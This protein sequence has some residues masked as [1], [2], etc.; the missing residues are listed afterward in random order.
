MTLQVGDQA[1]LFT[2]PDDNNQKIS[3]QDLRGKQ[4]VLYFYPKDETPGCTR[5]ACDFRDAIGK[6][7]Q[8]KVV[9]F[10]ISKDSVASH[11]KFKKN[12]VLSFPLLSDETGEVCEKYGVWGEKQMMGKKYMGVKRTTFL[13]DKNGIVSHIWHDVKVD[14]HVAVVLKTV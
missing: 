4:I 12:H 3:L 14:G 7:Q 2:L 1:P 5:E 8:K 10:G 11:Q 13:I 9:I 6:F